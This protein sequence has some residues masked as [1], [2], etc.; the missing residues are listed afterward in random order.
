MARLFL[1][2]SKRHNVTDRYGFA[3]WGILFEVCI[4]AM[5]FD[6]GASGCSFPPT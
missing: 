2:A 6:S 5:L 4:E 3:T 1:K